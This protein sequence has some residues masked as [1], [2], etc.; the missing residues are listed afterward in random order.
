MALLMLLPRNGAAYA[1]YTGTPIL[2]LHW[3]SKAVLLIGFSTIVFSITSLL[4]N[5]IIGFKISQTAA[6]LELALITPFLMAVF[7]GQLSPR[8]NCRIFIRSINT[9]VCLFS[10]WHLVV[11][12]GFPLRLPYIHYLPD[13]YWGAFGLGGAKI[14]TVIGFFGLIEILSTSSR[15]LKKPPTW[16]L[17]LTLLNFLMPNF[18]LGILAGVLGLSVFMQRYKKLIIVAVISAMLIAPY[19]LTRL[20]NANN[21][22]EEVYGLH[23]KIFA[24]VAVLNL[25]KD[26]TTTLFL[27]TGPGQY[28]SQ[29]ALWKSPISKVISSQSIPEFP[30]LFS[31]DAHSE[32]LAPYL[33]TFVNE[34]YA[35]SSSFNKPYTG[36]SML[37]AEFGLPL[38]LLVFWFLYRNFW[39]HG[40]G[41]IGKSAFLFTVSINLL[42]NQFDVPWFGALLIAT[43]SIIAKGNQSK[44]I[45]SNQDIPAPSSSS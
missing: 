20:D 1:A 3:R 28:S 43:G 24:Y 21:K 6:I 35:L 22:F 31:S 9:I 17:V 10:F 12:M 30:G 25:Y 42:D 23:P 11:D 5:S 15:G 8:L 14:V 32:Y 2:S 29:P 19:I 7:G 41:L 4:I 34:K 37:L 26:Q 39:V 38:T 44:Y 13:H 18:I 45:I 33:L 36:F 40:L 27:G 16:L